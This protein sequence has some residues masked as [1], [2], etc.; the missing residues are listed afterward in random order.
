MKKVILLLAAVAC[1]F[2]MYWGS[3]Y[4]R[5]EQQAVELIRPQVS[6][7]RD[8]VIL[9]GSITDSAP[10][11]LYADGTSVVKEILVKPGQTVRAGQ[12]LMRLERTEENSAPQEA[13]AAAMVQLQQALEDGDISAAEELVDSIVF[14]QNNPKYQNATTKA[15]QL[16]SP[17]D[18]T[19]ME[20][21]NGVGET[22]T[23]ILPCLVLC[24]A[25]NLHIEVQAEE[26]TVG[27]LQEEMVCEVTIP[28]FQTEIIEGRVEAIM[29][30][31]RQ[32][33]SLLNSSGSAKTTLHISVSEPAGL[34]PGYRAEVKVVTKYKSAALLVPYEAVR[35]DE[36]GQEYV[37]LMEQNTVCR[38]EIRT[39]SELDESVEVVEGIAAEDILLLSPDNVQEGDIVQYDLTGS[40]QAGTE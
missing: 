13:T 29:P 19:V 36:S 7:I 5:T 3:P 25:R 4:H 38:R 11:R 10:I 30:Y 6:D 2:G 28:A 16:Y 12:M 35:Q 18:C 9:Q 37:M 1:V 21:N 39:G 32:T 17:V 31:A 26:D 33:G 14:A 22:V 15:Y 8:M 23:G 24:D 40:D 27:M 34:K 20:I